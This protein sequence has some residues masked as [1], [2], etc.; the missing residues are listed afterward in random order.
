MHAKH[1][2]EWLWEHRAAEVAMEVETEVVGKMSGPE[3]WEQATTKEG[4]T[5]GGEERETTK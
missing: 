4:I 3:G 2:Q 5:D 1:L